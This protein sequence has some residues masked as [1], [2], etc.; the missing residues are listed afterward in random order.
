MPAADVLDVIKFSTT[1]AEKKCVDKSDMECEKK[2]SQRQLKVFC[3]TKLKD[4]VS[5]NQTM[6]GYKRKSG[7]GKIGSSVLDTWN[8][9]W[10]L[11]IQDELSENY[12]RE[13][14]IPRA[15]PTEMWKR[16]AIWFS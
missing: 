14:G 13:T 10:L 4:E 11:D 16:G 2:K 12:I 9:K 5:I 15:F 6:D 3:L 7:W 8:L 1:V